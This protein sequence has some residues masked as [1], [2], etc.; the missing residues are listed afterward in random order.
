MAK[1]HSMSKVIDSG[2]PPSREGTRYGP[3]LNVT[4]FLPALVIQVPSAA[5]ALL[6]NLRAGCSNSA[7]RVRERVWVT[8]DEAPNPNSRTVTEERLSACERK[9]TG[10]VDRV[11][12]DGS[13]ARWDEENGWAEFARALS[14]FPVQSDTTRGS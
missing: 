4:C 12:L 8:Y 6:P 7:V 1:S 2:M 10:S 11:N 14:Y 3:R 5:W 9:Y 13:R